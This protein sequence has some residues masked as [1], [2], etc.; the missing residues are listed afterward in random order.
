MEIYRKKGMTFQKMNEVA[1]KLKSLVDDYWKL[2][3]SEK[4][5]IDEIS[6]VFNSTN[7]RHL[8]MRGFSFKA[9]VA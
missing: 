2:K 1:E 3:I 6:A 5:F 4:E 9:G 8:I 7:N